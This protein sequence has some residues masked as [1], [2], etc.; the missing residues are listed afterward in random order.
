[1]EVIERADYVIV[2][3]EGQ[4]VYVPPLAYHAVLKVYS[5]NVVAVE[6]HFTLLCGT[7]FADVRRGSV[8]RDSIST[9]MRGH[10]TGVQ[11][12]NVKS[13]L[14]KYA[15]Y[16]KSPA[17]RRGSSKRQRRSEKAPKAIAKRWKG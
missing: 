17:I 5:E 2:Q 16:V 15:K 12:G 10:H 13:V 3:Q 14:K 11:H 9:W 6:E 4:S 7:F 8:W 1:M